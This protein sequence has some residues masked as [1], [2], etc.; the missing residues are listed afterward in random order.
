[1]FTLKKGYLLL[2]TENYVNFPEINA[3]LQNIQEGNMKLI[4]NKM[5][6]S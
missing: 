1:M 4:H 5:V 2:Y 3:D 6:V